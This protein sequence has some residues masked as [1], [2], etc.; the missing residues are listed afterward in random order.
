MTPT[1]NAAEAIGAIAPANPV[2]LSSAQATDV[3]SPVTNFGQWFSTE[4]QAV[5][6]QLVSAEHSVQQLAVGGVQNLHETMLQLE[7]A[8]LQFQ[9]M[10][11][12]RGKVLDAYQEVM[13][14]Q[15]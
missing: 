13:R 15:V 4:V 11:Q 12:L 5:N 3:T 10:I 14:M 8:R 2:A 9:L 6:A 7:Q 1:V